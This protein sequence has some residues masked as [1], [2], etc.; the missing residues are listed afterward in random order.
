MHVGKRSRL[1]LCLFVDAVMSR[2]ECVVVLQKHDISTDD[3]EEWHTG[4]SLLSSLKNA[5]LAADPSMIGAL[6]QELARTRQSIRHAVS[7]KHL[8]DE[9]WHD[10]VFS[11][12]LDGNA[13]VVDNHGSVAAAFIPIEPVID[14]SG[15]PE[16]DLTR[17]L[18]QSDL[19]ATEEVLRL[20]EVSAQDFIDG[21]YNGCLGN[22]RVA[23]ETTGR[24]IAASASPL[25]FEGSPKW[26]EALISL[27]EVGFI[28][29]D[30]EQGLAGVYR[31]ISPGS[32]VPVGFSESEFARLGRTLALS[33]T[34]FLIKKWNG[35]RGNRT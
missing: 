2:D 24:A 19:A 6:T 18:Q 28:S 8:F 27:R 35:V 12:N 26:G 23:L 1:S 3:I 4:N 14:G 13:L 7:P 21:K 30:Q 33:S 5:I 22:A 29:L 15:A 17:E 9:R 25:R 11:M 20:I 31:F 34:Y 32:H 16:D 10:F